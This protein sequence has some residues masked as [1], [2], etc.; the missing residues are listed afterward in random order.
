[1]INIFKNIFQTNYSF[2][3]YDWYKDEYNGLYGDFI[4]Y[5]IIKNHV[6]FDNKQLNEVLIV[7][8][9]TH[10]YSFENL[11]LFAFNLS[12]EI[13]DRKTS[14]NTLEIRTYVCKKLKSFLKG[15]NV[16]NINENIYGAFFMYVTYRIILRAVLRSNSKN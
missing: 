7:L 14:D 4:E 8:S 12:L 10:K 6:T 9:S 11:S 15:E 5:L 13:G 1:M 3:V 2:G 16:V